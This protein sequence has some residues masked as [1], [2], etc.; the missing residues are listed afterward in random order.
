MASRWN[1]LRGGERSE[2]ERSGFQRDARDLFLL[3]F[4]PPKHGHLKKIGSVVDIWLDAFHPHPIPTIPR[5][6]APRNKSCISL[7]GHFD[8]NRVAD[9]CFAHKP[10]APAPLDL[11]VASH[12]AHCQ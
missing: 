10:L 8:P 5:S 11:P 4:F 6:K 1:P 2:P 7:A 3:W 9:K 12:A